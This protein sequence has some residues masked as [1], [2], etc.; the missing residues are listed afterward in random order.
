MRKFIG[1]LLILSGCVLLGL[2]ARLLLLNENENLDA[3]QAS[4]QGV[5][6]LHTVISARTKHETKLPEIY[7][8][9]VP[10]EPLAKEDIPYEAETVQLDGTRYIGILALPTLGLEL[11]VAAR[12]SYPQLKSTPCRYYGSAETGDLVICGHNYSAVFG[13]LKDL[14]LGDPVYLT[15]ADG[16][17]H[18]YAVSVY[19]I[20][21]PT[22]IAKM[23]ESGAALT[24][25][26]CTY[27]GQQ[28]VT[29]RCT[30]IPHTAEQ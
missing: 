4:A 6:A 13:H 16:T 1:L 15:E 23:T 25:Y 19:E 29:I 21:E 20:L 10:A 22:D 3:K 26:T 8:E 28:R 30:E 2:S 18:S 17:L 12:W 7:R 14:H 27:G 11:P 24:L 9:D 5:T